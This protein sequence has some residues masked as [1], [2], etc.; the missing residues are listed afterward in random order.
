[1]NSRVRNIRRAKVVLEE[2]KVHVGSDV[3]VV[4]NDYLATNM[5]TATEGEFDSML[6][7]LKEA[8]KKIQCWKR[9][10]AAQL[11]KEKRA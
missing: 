1:M 2:A 10:R 5:S 7:L 3:I 4:S 6:V 8:S 11:K 9:T